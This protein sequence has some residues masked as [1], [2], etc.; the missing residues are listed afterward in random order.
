MAK[1]PDYRRNA[2]QLAGRQGPEHEW[3]R[4]GPRTRTW[5]PPNSSLSRP[6]IRSDRA[7]RA[8]LGKD[9]ERA[10]PQRLLHFPRRGFGYR[11]VSAGAQISMYR[12]LDPPAVR[13]ATW[14]PQTETGK[15]RLAVWLRLLPTS[16]R[17]VSRRGSSVAVPAGSAAPIW[18][19]RLFGRRAPDRRR[20][21]FG[22]QSVIRLA[23]PL[24]KCRLARKPAGTE[25][26]R[27]PQD[28]RSGRASSSHGGAARSSSGRDRKASS[29]TADIASRA[30]PIAS[31]QGP[32]AMT[33]MILRM[34]G[35]LGFTRARLSYF[36]RSKGLPDS[37]TIE[38]RPEAGCHGPR[39]NGAIR[40]RGGAGFR[41]L[42]WALNGGRGADNVSAG[43][44]R[45]LTPGL[46]PGS[47]E[48]GK[49]AWRFGISAGCCLYGRLSAERPIQGIRCERSG[50]K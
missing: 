15:S 18:P 46:E 27:Q 11:L 37:L 36:A 23:R 5:R 34:E 28:A 30:P 40:G 39:A 47:G 31:A 42:P 41:P 43:K 49:R 19:L 16:H 32:H 22:G 48:T 24:G 45:N 35:G 9:E 20:R 21:A 4:T 13:L 14:G 3:A 50:R 17:Q 1:Q 8:L 7:R 33:H 26:C 38:L 29:R 2:H 44:Y 25:T 10:A 12:N 6:L